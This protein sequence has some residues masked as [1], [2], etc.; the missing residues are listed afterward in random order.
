MHLLYGKFLVFIADVAVLYLF[1]K[2]IIDYSNA[3]YSSWVVYDLGQNQLS[4]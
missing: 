2:E 3:N 1:T 4:V